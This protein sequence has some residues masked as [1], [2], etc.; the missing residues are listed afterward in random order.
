M[1]GGLNKTTSTLAIAAAA[2][3]MLGGMMLPTAARAA[4]LGG[5][6]CAD[7][8]SRVAELE[9]TTVRK[10]NKKVS[11]TI[12]GRVAA[13]MMIWNDSGP[14][15]TVDNGPY[16]HLNDLSFGNVGDGPNI[17]LKGEGKI[18]SDLVAG[19]SMEIGNNFL[20]FDQANHSTG[21][22]FSNDNVYVYLSSKS[23]GT[24][25][26]GKVDSAGDQFNV[27]YDGSWIGG[28]ASRRANGRF[29]VREDGSGIFTT[30]RVQDY[31][32]TL[33]H[34]GDPGLR[35]ISPSFGGFSFGASIAG[36]DRTGLGANFAHTSGTVTIGLGL[37]LGRDTRQD[38]GSVDTTVNYTGLSAGLKESSSGLF[39]SG[40]WTKK[41]TEVAGVTTD[42]TN[43]FINGG[44][45]KNVSGAG[46]TTIHVSY[47]R[48]N[49][50]AGLTSV[51]HTTVVG[52]DQ[53]FDAAETHLYLQWEGTS[54]DTP[55]LGDAAETY[56]SVTMGMAISY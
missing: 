18:R 13:A 43:L 39:L 26:L 45:A 31:L 29:F 27:N 44:W 36:D 12:T 7:L 30:R 42:A 19:F 4:D 28:F 46:D 40:D 49:D 37:G 21:T 11:L 24:L 2:S 53:K 23:L 33:E 50:V 47:D 52:I 1:T 35:Y 20:G 14:V 25:Q 8:E 41:S 38:A 22:A 34:G 54:I 17:V 32:N 9:A 5:D 56:S 51:A 10:G 6:C 15:N 16:D 55:I 3:L 48:S